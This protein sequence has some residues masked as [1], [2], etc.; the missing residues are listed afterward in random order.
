MGGAVGSVKTKEV[1]INE[2]HKARKLNRDDER[3]RM[4]TSDACVYAGGSVESLTGWMLRRR[5]ERW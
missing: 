3:N 2:K 5:Y 4:M 1:E